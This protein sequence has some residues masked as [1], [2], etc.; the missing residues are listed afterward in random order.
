MKKKEQLFCH[1]CFKPI[2]KTKEYIEVINKNHDDN[3]NFDIPYGHFHVKC[4]DGI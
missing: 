4:Y 3:V 2:D 1:V